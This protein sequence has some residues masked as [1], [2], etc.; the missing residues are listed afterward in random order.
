MCTSGNQ[1]DFLLILHSGLLLEGSGKPYKVSEIKSGWVCAKQY[2]LHY[3]NGSH[4][5]LYFIFHAVYFYIYL[6]IVIYNTVNNKVLS[7]W[8]SNIK[9]TITGS[10]FKPL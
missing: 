9:P 10:C 2:S 7:V 1:Q 4:K 8:F 3:R 6:S 5:I